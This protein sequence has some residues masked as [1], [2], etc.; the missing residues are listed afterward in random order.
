MS[1]ID[2]TVLLSCHQWSVP[3][4]LHT[5]PNVVSVFLIFAILTDV[6]LIVD[7]T[8]LSLMLSIFCVF[9]CHYVSCWWGVHVFIEIFKA[10]YKFCIPILCQIY[11]LWIFSQS[12]TCLFSFLVVWVFCVCFFLNIVALL[13]MSPSPSPLCPTLSR[14]SFHP[15]PRPPSLYYF[16]C[17]W[18]M[19]YAV[20][21]S[22]IT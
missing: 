9:I 11:V 21:Q 17:L 10:L 15:H 6:Y 16:L 7:L 1:Q 8:C 20:N 3:V 12:F 4:A 5:L 14:A 19:Q 13:Q 2:C 22:G 18:T